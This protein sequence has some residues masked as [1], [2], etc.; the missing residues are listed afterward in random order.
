[1]ISRQS[2]RRP[3]ILWIVGIAALALF[4][5]VLA[6]RGPGGVEQRRVSYRQAGIATSEEELELALPPMPDA[7]NEASKLRAAMSGWKRLNPGSELEFQAVDSLIQSTPALV[8]NFQAELMANRASVELLHSITNPSHSRIGRQLKSQS[9]SPDL[10][11][12]YQKSLQ[13]SSG[14]LRLECRVQRF[15]GDPEKA[16]RAFVSGLRVVRILENTRTMPGHWD[17]LHLLDGWLHELEWL[18][19][20]GP[21]TG[22]SLELL[23]RELELHDERLGLPL[24]M[25]ALRVSTFELFGRQWI[26]STGSNPGPVYQP[27]PIERVLIKLYVGSG[28][29]SRDLL[30][31]LDLMDR[32]AA[33]A[34]KPTE[35]FQAAEPPV[36]RVT[37]ITAGLRLAVSHGEIVT[38][39]SVHELWNRRLELVARLRCARTAVAVE[40]WRGLHER[41]I[42][43]RLEILV[44][45]VMPSVLLQPS[46]VAPLLYSTRDSGYSIE[47]PHGDSTRPPIVFAVGLPSAHP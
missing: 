40:R 13:E 26:D 18:L 46:G 9:D 28:I 8:T 11:Y 24:V 25:Q 10:F 42:P 23:Q 22:A 2:G 41:E 29:P 44:P 14:V 12:Q 1:M 39:E 38:G 17:H 21:V 27:G 3:G 20:R 37:G 34:E 7:E 33:L 31:S 32:F 30:R 19:S 15:R 6:A 4:L 36:N 43:K 47:T 35:A 5:V 16:T 45:E